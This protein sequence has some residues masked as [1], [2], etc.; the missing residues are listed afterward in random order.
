MA[1]TVD[2]SKGTDQTRQLNGRRMILY[3]E[4]EVTRENLPFIL[5]KAFT[6]HDI[7]RSEIQYLWDYYRGIQPILNRIKKVRPEICNKIVMN[8]AQEIV[9]F[10]VGYSFGEPM[11]YVGR[12]GEEAVT[13]MVSHL[14][15]LLFAEDKIPKDRDVFEW[16]MI[17][18]TAF[19][20]VLPDLPDEADDAPFEI[21]TLDPRNTFVVYSA[22]VGN[23]PL[24]GVKYLTDDLGHRTLTA[25]SE[26]AVYTLEEGEIVDERPNPLRDVPIYEY[27][28]NN[29][30][31]GA[32]EI[33]IPLMDALNKITSNRLDSDEQVVQAFI[34]FINCDISSAD[35][36]ALKEKGAIKVKSVDGAPADVDIVSTHLVQ[37]ETQTMKNDIYNAILTICGIPNRNG[38]SSTS[39]NG[40]AVVYRD[41]WEAA[42]TRAKDYELMF[43][44][45]EKRMLKTLLRICRDVDPELAGLRLKDIDIKFT[46]RNYENIQSKAQVLISM[47]QEPKVHPLTAYETCGLF[48]D[49]ENAYSLGMKYYE[50]QMSK[51]EP[52]AVDETAAEAEEEV[53]EDENV[54]S[55]GQLP[56]EA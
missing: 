56:K 32:F 18:G 48:T 50:E 30:R 35:F 38:G 12:T 3:P 4:V 55:N 40:I 33:V 41:G 21:Y 54:S 19:R 1:N 17:C 24:L 20:L 11:Q 31:L 45:S 44:K 49:P 47:L 9:A 15:E 28:A 13:K 8:I 26:T 51:W 29:A 25:Y 5:E 10:K 46:R 34:K 36:D 52:V 53:T 23:K 37:T 14:N 27:P 43:K 42:E 6:V 7:N 16:S 39:D 2:Y 22:E